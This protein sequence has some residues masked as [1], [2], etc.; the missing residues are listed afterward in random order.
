MGKYM[1][2]YPF[3]KIDQPI[4]GLVYARVKGFQEARYDFSLF[5]DDTYHLDESYISNAY[6]FLTQNRSFGI[7]GGYAKP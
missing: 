2:K 6:P 7:L 5:C 4:Q 3:K 1:L